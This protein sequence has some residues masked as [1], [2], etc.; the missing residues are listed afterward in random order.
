MVK[1]LYYI[2]AQSIKNKSTYEK[3]MIKKGVTGEDHT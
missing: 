2:L 3:I 1:L